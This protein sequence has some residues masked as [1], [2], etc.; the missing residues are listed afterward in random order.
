MGL[1]T[2]FLFTTNSDLNVS[3]TSGV[4]FELVTKPA[5]EPLSLTQVKEN[6]RIRN[7]RFDL[8]ITR[9]ISEARQWIEI[10]TGQMFIEQTWRQIHN[11][12]GSLLVG[13]GSNRLPFSSGSNLVSLHLE[14]ARSI[15]SVKVWPTLASTTQTTV[16]ATDYFLT[17]QTLTPRTT[18]PST[19]GI[20]GFE[21]EY[22]VGH[23]SNAADFDSSR[24]LPLRRALDLVIAYLFE[25]PGDNVTFESKGGSTSVRSLPPEAMAMLDSYVRYEL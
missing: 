7:A 15:V 3:L 19:R 8:L 24:A 22:K 17:G 14:K 20:G 5:E 9:I 13:L 4:I 16:A 18:W 12:T 2:E 6:L 25:N 23:A 1:A 11:S 21:V 10:V